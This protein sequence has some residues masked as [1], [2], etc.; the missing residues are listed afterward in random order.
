MDL[1]SK[2]KDPSRTKYFLWINVQFRRVTKT[3][4]AIQ[5][6]T[7]NIK[8]D[9][10]VIL[11][12]YFCFTHGHNHYK[13]TQALVKYSLIPNLWTRLPQ[14]HTVCSISPPRPQ[15]V[16]LAFWNSHSWSWPPRGDCY[17]LPYKTDCISLEVHKYG[18]GP[19][20]CPQSRL[21]L[22]PSQTWRPLTWLVLQD[23]KN[24]QQH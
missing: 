18:G 24:P 4:H 9:L 8:N 21:H 10:K 5:S 15:F 13:N 6:S 1:S 11:P 22:M 20:C 7:L 16:F 23:Q 19:R 3:S 2:Q 12:F 14:L 17:P